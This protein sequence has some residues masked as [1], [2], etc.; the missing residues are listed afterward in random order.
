MPSPQIPY[1][2]AE[3]NQKPW[4][5]GHGDGWSWQET[6]MQVGAGPLEHAAAWLES[7]YEVCTNLRPKMLAPH[8]GHIDICAI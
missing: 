5:P 7:C 4:L 8:V 1:Y 2:M 6:A 3:G